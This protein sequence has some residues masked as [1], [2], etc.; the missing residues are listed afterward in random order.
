MAFLGLATPCVSTAAETPPASDVGVQPVPEHPALTDR[1]A[2]TLGGY[3]PGTSTAARL[4]P[5]TGVGVV[6]DFEDALGIDDKKLVIEGSF[7]WRINEHWRLDT[8]YFSLN[9]TSSRVLEEQIEWGD[10]VFPIGADVDTR[11]KISDLRA[12]VGYSFFSRRDKELG[13]GLGIHASKFLASLEG[14]GGLAEAT[15]VTAPLPVVNFYASTALT[16]TWAMTTRL[17]WLS[18][19]YGDYSGD[20]RFVALDFLYQPFQTIGF[21]FGFHSLLYDLE[22]DSTD[23]RGRARLQIQGPSAFMTASF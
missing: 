22:M 12:A 23:W 7:R 14:S 20:I 17:D 15:D 11:F 19:S 10:E 8:N 4:D 2:F 5:N 16:D 13:I 21:G 6:V 18:L 1:F 9:R 3:Y